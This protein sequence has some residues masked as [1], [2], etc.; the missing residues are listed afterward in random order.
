MYLMIAMIMLQTCFLGNGLQRNRSI[1]ILHLNAT[2]LDWN[3][4][5][6]LAFAISVL[7]SQSDILPEYNIT[8]FTHHAGIV[9]LLIFPND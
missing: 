6:S 2:F 8:Y 3:S 1:N 5:L 4:E 9:S 7:H